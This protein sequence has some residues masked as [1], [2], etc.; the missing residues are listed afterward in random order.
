MIKCPD[1]TN[2]SDDKTGSAL[3][4]M[5]IMHVFPHKGQHQVKIDFCEEQKRRQIT[6][7]VLNL[8]ICC[9]SVQVQRRGGTLTGTLT[10]RKQSGT[11]WHRGSP[12]E[13]EN[14]VFQSS[15]DASISEKAN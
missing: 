8:V 11:L 12:T 5:G 10:A 7:E 1:V 15:W 14:N 9:T 6:F 2:A 13:T 3:K 4:M